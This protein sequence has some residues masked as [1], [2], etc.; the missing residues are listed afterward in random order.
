MKIIIIS[1]GKHGNGRVIAEELMGIVKDSG[2]EAH[3]YSVEDVKPEK[4]QEGDL[5]VFVSPTH[6]MGPSRKMKKAVEKGLFPENGAYGLIT[7]SKKQKRKTAR[8]MEK[9]LEKRGLS[10]EV[11]NLH[12]LEDK[13]GNLKKGF[14][15]ELEKFYGMI[16]SH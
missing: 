1:E 10:K 8:K 15:D 11:E 16:E 6:A 12:L 2:R 7:I 13:K 4:I 9:Y 14:R 5:Y 3:I